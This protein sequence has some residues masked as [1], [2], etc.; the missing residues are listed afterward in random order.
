MSPK[1]PIDRALEE[2]LK[3]DSE[4]S[5]AYKEAAGEKPPAAL[6]AAILQEARHAV[7]HGG[8]VAR[9]PFARTWLVPASLAAVLL[10]TVGLVT[11]VSRESGEAPSPAGA[12][13][14]ALEADRLQSQQPRSKLEAQ[15][16]AAPLAE[17]PALMMQ[18]KVPA[19][20]KAAPAP[21]P[22]KMRTDAPASV[23]PAMVPA[24]STERMRARDE[25]GRKSKEDKREQRPPAALTATEMRALSP[26]EWL[27]RIAQL[28]EQGKHDEAEASL[29]AFKKRYPDYPIEKFL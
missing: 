11:F 16:P 24:E 26:E 17:E 18:Q 20:K 27:K 4:L 2:Y 3:N 14:R 10:L 15:A 29:A 5:R 25:V 23:T 28:R 6:D 19:E 12:P 22:A 21:P 13:R 9:G 7:D 8:R 1:E